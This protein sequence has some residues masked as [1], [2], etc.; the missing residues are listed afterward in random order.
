MS[1]ASGFVA[2]SVLWL[3]TAL[4]FMGWLV[5]EAEREEPYSED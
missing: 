5:W 1:F 4:A 3:G 2:G